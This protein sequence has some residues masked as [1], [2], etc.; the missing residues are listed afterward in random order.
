VYPSAVG[1]PENPLSQ[2]SQS[3]PFPMPAN[4]FNPNQNGCLKFKKPSA[5]QNL[6]VYISHKEDNYTH[7]CQLAELLAEQHEIICMLPFCE[8]LF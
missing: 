2:H 3:N 6:P 7:Y 4:H 1:T 8:T 5:I